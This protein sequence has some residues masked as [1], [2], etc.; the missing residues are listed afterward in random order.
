MNLQKFKPSAIP[1]WHFKNRFYLWNNHVCVHC[2]KGRRCNEHPRANICS[3][4][5]M[6]WREFEMQKLAAL[7]Q[8]AGLEW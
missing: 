3:A 8:K 1:W 5:E 4:C 2:I 6:L 7:R